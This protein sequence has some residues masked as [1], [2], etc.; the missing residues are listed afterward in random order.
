M[1]LTKLYRLAGLSSS[2]R[3]DVRAILLVSD[4]TLLRDVNHSAPVGDRLVVD[5]E[6]RGRVP[7]G[8]SFVVDRD[9]EAEVMARS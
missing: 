4:L 5:P 9:L 7:V 6:T 8:L 2:L 3:T 1:Y